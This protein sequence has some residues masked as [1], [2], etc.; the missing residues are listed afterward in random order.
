MMFNQGGAALTPVTV[1]HVS[2]AVDLFYLCCM[3][4]TTDYSIVVFF[5][6][7]VRDVFFVLMDVVQRALGV[8]FQELR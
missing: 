3:Y 7:V 6:A 1:I 2:D 8:G 5:L 4:V